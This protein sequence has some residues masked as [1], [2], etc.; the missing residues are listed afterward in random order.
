MGQS[1]KVVPSRDGT[2]DGTRAMDRHG[3]TFVFVGAVEG[4]LSVNT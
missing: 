2:G 4:N 1:G 3:V